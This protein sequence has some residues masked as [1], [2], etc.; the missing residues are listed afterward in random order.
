MDDAEEDAH[1]AAVRADM[2][3]SC[4]VPAGV[5]GNPRPQLVVA[6]LDINQGRPSL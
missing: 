1:A 3:L 4:K 6:T 2:D 5:A